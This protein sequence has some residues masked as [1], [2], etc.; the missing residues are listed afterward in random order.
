MRLHFRLISG[1]LQLR[2]TCHKNIFFSFSQFIK[3]D[4]LST[5]LMRACPAHPPETPTY[6]CSHAA[7]IFLSISKPLSRKMLDLKH[8]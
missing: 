6:Q 3:E 5:H 1:F 2:L 8:S 7:A 4:Q